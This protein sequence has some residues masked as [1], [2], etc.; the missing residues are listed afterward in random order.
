MNRIFPLLLLLNVAFAYT[1]FTNNSTV[2]YNVDAVE[3]VN[4]KTID[5]PFYDFFYST[6]IN[7]Y[8]ELCNVTEYFYPVI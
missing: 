1:N 5:I 7:C 3:C 2:T 4:N 8:G 6:I